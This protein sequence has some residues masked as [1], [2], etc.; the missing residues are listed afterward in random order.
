MTQRQLEL[1]SSILALTTRG[2]RGER[3]RE[4]EAEGEGVGS[5]APAAVAV[6]E[7]SVVEGEGVVGAKMGGMLSTP[8]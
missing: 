8:R 6:A 2:E 1:G 7:R 5:G 3:G 4:E